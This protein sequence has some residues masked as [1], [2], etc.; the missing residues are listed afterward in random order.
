MQDLQNCLFLPKYTRM[1]R[2]FSNYFLGILATNEINISLSSV[3]SR[4]QHSLFTHD[5]VS[6][7]DFT[8]IIGSADGTGGPD[9][10]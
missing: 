2:G 8:I 4:L 1:Y 7:S 10:K 9:L 6:A 3:L 5:C